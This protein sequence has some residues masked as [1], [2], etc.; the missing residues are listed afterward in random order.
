A[1]SSESEPRSQ[2]SAD[3]AAEDS[4]R[5]CQREA[6]KDRC[7]YVCEESHDPDWVG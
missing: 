3:K 7:F 2:K 5:D 4:A 6:V 1:L